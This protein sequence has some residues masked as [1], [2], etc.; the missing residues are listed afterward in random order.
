MRENRSSDTAL[1]VVTIRAVHHLIDDVPHILDDPI[2][3]LLLGAQGVR[4]ILEHP[5]MHRSLPSRALRSH[6]VLRSRYAEDELARAVASGI[7]QTVNLGAGYDTF[8]FRQPDWARSIRIVELDHPATQSAKVA[9][10]KKAG[11]PTPD[12]LEWVPLDLERSDLGAG[13]AASSLDPALPAFVACLGV[14]AYLRPGTVSALFHG[15][16]ALQKG[17]RFVFAFASAQAEATVQTGSSAAVRAAAHGE[18]WLTRFSRDELHAELLRS[19]FSDVHFLDPDA[20]AAYYVG[21][22]DLPAPRPTRI[23]HAVV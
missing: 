17:S 11:L 3:P 15:V 19:G 22:H 10:L 5:E 4:R 7:R 18:P 14:V 12:N 13:L 21:R 9:L 2:A 8:A 1:D 23:C 20:A 6:V 16:A